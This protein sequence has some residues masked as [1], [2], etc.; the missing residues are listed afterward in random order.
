MSATCRTIGCRVH[1]SCTG[2]VFEHDTPDYDDTPPTTRDH[3]GM[4]G[5]DCPACFRA[6]SGTCDE[7][8][9]AKGA[10]INWEWK[11]GAA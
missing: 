8:L 4:P 10:Y 9:E 11:R 5:R 3:S 2:D 6:P 1:Y 7:H